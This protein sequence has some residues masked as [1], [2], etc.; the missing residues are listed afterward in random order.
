LTQAFARILKPLGIPLLTIENQ[1]ST[2]VNKS[3]QIPTWV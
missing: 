3:D 1:V 2:N